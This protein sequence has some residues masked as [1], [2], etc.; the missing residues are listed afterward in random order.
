M[1]AMDHCV[2]SQLLP[3]WN[4][5]MLHLW[6]YRS[7]ICGYCVAAGS[8]SVWCVSAWSKD[9]RWYY[10]VRSTGMWSS[11]ILYKYAFE[12]GLLKPCIGLIEV[13][14]TSVAKDPQNGSVHLTKLVDD[15]DK[16]QLDEITTDGIFM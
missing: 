1:T 14:M 2:S 15:C 13:N 8:E 10:R 11:Y 9:P 3:Y 6:M 16:A 7:Q 5:M 4:G 12:L